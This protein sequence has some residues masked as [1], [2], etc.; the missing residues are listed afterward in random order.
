MPGFLRFFLL[1]FSMANFEPKALLLPKATGPL[2]RLKW[3]PPRSLENEFKLDS[4]QPG[5]ASAQLRK[6]LL[7][8]SSHFYFLS[9]FQI[10]TIPA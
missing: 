7:L 5:S 2:E 9:L 1:P 4:K 8:F 3:L 6:T 10:H